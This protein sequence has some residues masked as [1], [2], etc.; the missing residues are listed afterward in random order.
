MGTV[1]GLTADRMLQIEASSVVS[2]AVDGTGHLVLTQ[3]NGATMDAGSV[4]GPQGPQ[5]ATGATG[6]SGAITGEIKQWPVATA[7]SGYLLCNGQLVSR[8]TYSALF[9]L[10]GT[11]FGAGDG[12]TTFALPD[13]RGRFPVGAGGTL[14]GPVGTN[15]TVNVNTKGGTTK[16]NH[17]LNDKGQAQ[18]LHPG[19]N[20]TIVFRSI[21]SQAWN[22]TDSV[23]AT[24][25]ETTSTTS[26]SFGSALMGTTEDYASPPPYI[27]MSFIIKT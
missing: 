23:T 16:H 22:Q 4:I 11:T 26:R 18:V 25:Q 20:S 7:P 19:G 27:G 10:I 6:P 5:G 9:T 17:T 24:S 12:S 14:E 1:T 13:Y 3:H 21:N 8:T 15:T 2:G